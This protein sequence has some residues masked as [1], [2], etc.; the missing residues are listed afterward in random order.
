MRF[1]RLLPLLLVSLSPALAQDYVVTTRRDT[2]R[3]SLTIH[4]NPTA[5]RVVVVQPN[6]KTDYAAYQVLRIWMDS[7]LYQPVRTTEAFRFMR[8]ARG[9]MVSLCYARQSPGTPYN[10]PYLVK[11]SGESMEVNAL[12]FKKTTSRFL[13]ECNSIRQKIEEE[14]LGRNDLD[15]IVEGYNRC[16]EQQT[17][18]AFTTSEDPKL[19][20]LNAF[21]KKVSKDTAIPSEVT[22]ILKDLFMKV[23]EGKPVPQYLAEGLRTSLKDFPAYAQDVESLLAVLQK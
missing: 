5:D 12:R 3:G 11:I 7:V 15:K 1:P 19:S 6:G 16:L 22:E 14:S 10:I 4:S 18:V 23:K 13:S 9:G 20:A 2:V 8:I 21:N 17:T